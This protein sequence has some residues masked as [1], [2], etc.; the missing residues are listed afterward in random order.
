MIMMDLLNN[1][2]AP[3]FVLLGIS[4]IS[5]ISFAISV[6]RL[7]QKYRKKPVDLDALIA[8]APYH[9]LDE[10]LKKSN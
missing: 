7:E 1:P 3:A 4:A 8:R 10:V 6:H 5:V 9:K 2:A